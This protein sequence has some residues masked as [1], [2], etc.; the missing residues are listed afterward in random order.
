MKM[1]T[2]KMDLRKNAI[3]KKIEPG[4]LNEMSN[5]ELKNII[6][7]MLADHLSAQSRTEQEP[8]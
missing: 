1:D 8:K 7:S 5:K 2:E 3:R 6:S 4:E